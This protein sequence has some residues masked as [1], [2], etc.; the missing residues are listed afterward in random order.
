MLHKVYRDSLSTLT[1]LY[2]LT[3]M[4]GYW[5][6]EMADRKAVFHLYFRKNPFQGD[7]AITAGLDLVI[8]WL[9]QF[10]FPYED[11]RYLAQLKG[12]DGR[13]LFQEGFLNFLQRSSFECDVH[14][15]PEG[16]IVFPNQPLIRVEGPLWQG[17]YIETALLTLMNFSTLIATKAG[18]IVQAAQGDEVLEFGLRR[19]QGIDGGLTATRSAYIGGCSAT[20]NVLAGKTLE[21]PVK[22]T[23]AHSWVMCFEEELDAFDAYANAL[24]NNCIFLVDTYNTEEGVKKAIKIGKKLRAKGQELIGIRLDSGDLNALS[25]KARQLLN[26]AGFDQTKIVASNDLDE[27]R[28]KV[29][30]A[31]GAQI[32]LW[33]IGTRLV[34]ARNQPALGGVYKLAAIQDKNGNWQ[35]K[36]KLSEEFLKVSNPGCLQVRRLTH[37]SGI[38]EKDVLYNQ[39]EHQLQESSSRKGIIEKDLLI[40]IYRKGKRVY[41]SPDI[42]QIRAH[43]LAEQQLIQRTL[44][45]LGRPYSQEMDPLLRNLKQQIVAQHR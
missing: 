8:S 12:R 37:T 42:H 25:Q 2:Q 45:E 44:A 10:S 17:Q 24:P 1:D 39:W 9:D 21:I 16:T 31:T 4:N 22:G 38:H 36:V 34:T 32:D 11:I 26:A 20:S 27:D 7:Y 41:E 29:L 18:R 13:P 3:M 30:K 19:A 40:P 35:P 33:G 15:I 23:H 28:I 6:N 5:K 43:S 14:A